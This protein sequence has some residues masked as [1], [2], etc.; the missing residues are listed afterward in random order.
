MKNIFW[1]LFFL[2]VAA[3]A[4]VPTASVQI[5]SGTTAQRPTEDLKSGETRWNTDSTALETWTGTMWIQHGGGGGSGTDDQ[6]LSWNSST[7]ELSIESG[8][9][10][11]LDGRY[12]QTEVDGS[13]TNEIQTVDTFSLSDDLRIS[14]SLEN[15]GEWANVLDMRETIEDHFGNSFLQNGPGMAW[16]YDDGGN[17]LVLESD[18]FVDT[19]ALVGTTLR[20]S[21]ENDKQPFKTADL[22]GLQDGTGT[23]DQTVSWNGSTGELS[24]EDGNTV[25][26][27]GRY[28]QSFTEVDGSVTNEGS[29]T[30]GAGTATT[31]LINS[32]TSGSTAVTL[33]VTGGLAISE[34]GNTITLDGSGI[35]G[36]GDNLGNHSATQDL[37]MNSYDIAE[38][39][40]AQWTATGI[41]KAFNQGGKNSWTLTGLNP[42]D[43]RLEVSTAGQLTINEEYSF[44]IADGTAG[45]VLTTDGS[46]AV[47]WET[48]AAGGS[49]SVISPSQITT[50]QNN[51]SP[52]GWAGATLVRLS[53]D[54]GFRA[55]TGFAAGTAG[56]V[57]TLTN[58]GSFCL[59]LA[60]EHSGSTAANRIAFQE[61]V[62][63][64]PGSSCQILYDGTSSRWRPMSSPSP[65]YKVPTKTKYYDEGLARAS[66]AAAADNALDIWG[67]IVPGV[68][69]ASSSEVFSAI[70]LN[71]G[72][73]SSGGCGIMYPHDL[74]GA[75]ITSSHIVIKTFVKT[76][77]AASDGTNTWYYFVRIADNPYSGFFNQNN[78][79]GLRAGNGVTNA[80]NWEAYSRSSGGTDTVVDT[81]VAFA[82]NT[83]VELMVSLNKAGT[84][85]TYWINGNVVARITTNL[86][87]AT[88]VGWSQQLEKQAGTSARSFKVYSF[89]GAAIAP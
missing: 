38:I 70:D 31:S 42:A 39:D 76:P 17:E 4:Q 65:M 45:Q 75:Y 50:D 5:P 71:T 72:S 59:Y 36:S 34:S 35:S 30:V 62:I 66:T 47:T 58:V 89:M 2:P 40:T 78:T 64:W 83:D 74:E 81:G 7:G 48:P 79:I 12:L 88:T 16:T 24:I 73:T 55:I 57:K 13:V 69:N 32:N 10:V 77:S 82:T 15:D 20:L 87:S 53:G 84:E 3:I 26:L 22:S 63:L 56:E 29:L 21:I 44:P 18:Q 8:N 6:T 49:P 61:E 25:D 46:G 43:I 1:I 52:T 23:D 51:Y 11:D 41:W 54:S 67:S 60:P 68:V 85:A 37:D 28:L 80:S 14:L 9:T 19:F 33:E 86:P 27:D